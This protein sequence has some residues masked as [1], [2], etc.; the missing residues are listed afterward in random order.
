[1]R[2]P[3]A[4]VLNVDCAFRE[5]PGYA[6]EEQRIERSGAVL[7]LQPARTEDDI[8]EAAREANIVL[9]EYGDTPLTA[10]VIG[11]LPACWALVKY[12]IGVDNVDVAAATANGIVVANAAEF[13]VEE[14]SDHAIALLLAGVRRI[15]AMDRNIRSGGWFDFPDRNSL[16]RMR[17]LTLGL[18]GFGRIA[19]AVARKLSGFEMRILA[20]DP[21]A[22]PASVPG[23]VTL[24]SREVLLR[25][26][27]LLSIHV[28]LTSETRGLVGEAELRAMKSTAIVVNTGRG[29]VI[30]QDA[31]VCALREKRIAAA[32]LDVFTEEPLPA[33]SPLREFTNVTL[34]PHYGARSEDS[35]IDLRHTV[36]DSVEALIRGYWPPY[37]VNPGVSPRIPLRPWKEFV[38]ER[39][40][41]L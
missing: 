33:N 29:P 36:A 21:Y 41:S 27:D 24:V 11:G 37:P 38:S 25:E 12:G 20:H 26:A 32:A 5:D 4:V 7:R 10:R 31:L 40:E 39:Q 14:V 1:M 28:P 30:D 15:V 8:L 16:R 35:I 34:T 23:H 13:C 9:L 2:K 19:R 3:A 6:Y 22:A 18:L 17:N